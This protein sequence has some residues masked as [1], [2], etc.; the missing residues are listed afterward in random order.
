MTSLAFPGPDR[1]QEPLQLLVHK[2]CF[3]G[4]NEESIII[5]IIQW[6]LHCVFPSIVYR[7]QQ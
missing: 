5:I 6:L 4:I 3:K 7:E 2:N 1:V